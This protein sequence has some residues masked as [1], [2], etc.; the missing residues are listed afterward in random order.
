MEIKPDVIEGVKDTVVKGISGRGI[1]DLPV[2][3]GKMSGMSVMVSRW[4]PTPEERK[5]I[6][7]GGDVYLCVYGPDHP[8]VYV[9]GKRPIAWEISMPQ[10]HIGLPT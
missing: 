9:S 10:I 5:Q 8:P 4:A 6:A 3:A 2:A 7:E 1:A